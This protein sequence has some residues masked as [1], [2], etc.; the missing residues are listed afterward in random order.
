MPLIDTHC[1][2]DFPLLAA[3]RDAVLQRARDAGVSR[4]VV[5]AY[6]PSDWP[7]VAALPKA[8]PGQI[9]AAFG[10][11]PWAVRD[12]DGDGDDDRDALAQH[13][14]APGTVALGE[15]GLDF[16]DERPPRPRQIARCRAQLALACDLGLPVIL[17]VHRAHDDLLALLAPFAPAL[18]GIVHGWTRSPQL[19]E[20]YLRLGLHLGLGLSLLKPSHQNARRTA[21]TAPLSRL[22]LET[23]APAA[24]AQS[25]LAPHT[26]P[27]HTALV[28]RELAQLRNTDAKEMARITSQN[29]QQLLGLS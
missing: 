25:P 1:H 15:I 18:R 9:F 6:Q 7:A 2:L 24:M 27:A 19:A 22:L 11:H 23:D 14:Q 8:H 5:P 13:L 17:H 10:T 12:T 26:E 21:A 28:A 4:I 20:R 29:A 16:G 3:N